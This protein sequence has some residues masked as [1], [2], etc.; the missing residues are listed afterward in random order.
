MKKGTR[1]YLADLWLNDQ[2]V[3]S[4]EIFT[5]T[6]IEGSKVTVR[7]EQGEIRTVNAKATVIRNIT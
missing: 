6:G 4:G 5:V 2:V 1:L 3:I 7:G